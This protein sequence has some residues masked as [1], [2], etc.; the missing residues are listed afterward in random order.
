MMGN[1]RI[2]TISNVLDDCTKRGVAIDLNRV[3]ETTTVLQAEQGSMRAQ[4]IDTCGE[5]FSIENQWQLGVVLF[6]KLGLIG[7]AELKRLNQD[8][9]QGEV[10]FEEEKG[11]HAKYYKQTKLVGDFLRRQQLD[12]RHVMRRPTIAAMYATFD[13]APTIAAMFWQRVCDG[14]GINNK[15]D[16]CGRLRTELLRTAINVGGSRTSQDIKCVDSETMYRWCIQAW[17][18]YRAGEELKAF[19]V[20]LDKA[21]PAV[22]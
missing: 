2:P 9:R 5:E 10:K 11:I 17:N 3:S 8:T 18:C 22:K 14:L 4:I 6:E 16:P 15:N 19:R 7:E 1:W 13:K 20:D 21:R 12:T